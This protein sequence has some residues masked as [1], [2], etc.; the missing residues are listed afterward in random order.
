MSSA[1]GEPPDSGVMKSAEAV[2]VQVRSSATAASAASASSR[3]RPGRDDGGLKAAGILCTWPADGAHPG[4]RSASAERRCAL[5]HEGGHAL[6]EV[7]GSRHLLLDRGLE[8]E[9]VLHPAEE[10]RVELALGP[11]V[12]LRGA[13]CQALDEPAR[14]ALEGVVGEHAVD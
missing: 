9:L 12:G 1:F 2:A 3:E 14:L 5:L 10:P 13:V 7:V 11:R 8:R 4:A 6:D